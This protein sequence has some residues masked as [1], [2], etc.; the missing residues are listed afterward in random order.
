M[1]ESIKKHLES[2]RELDLVEYILNDRKEPYGL[3][4]SHLSKVRFTKIDRKRLDLSDKIKEFSLLTRNQL[5]YVL[6]W[7]IGNAKYWKEMYEIVNNTYEIAK[8]TYEY[9]IVER[10]ESLRNEF[11]NR[12]KKPAIIVP[13]KKHFKTN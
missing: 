4:I 9:E 10:D 2:M 12:N 13:F 8:S 1:E 5:I 11:F 7:E 3:R 6:A